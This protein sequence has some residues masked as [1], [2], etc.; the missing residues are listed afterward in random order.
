LTSVKHHLTAKEITGSILSIIIAAV[1]LFIA[2]KGIHPQE[3][4]NVLR[5]TSPVWALIFAFSVTLSHFIRAYRWKLLLEN[6]KPDI[7]VHHSFAAVMIG[8]GINNVVPRL[9]E[10]SRAVFLGQYE[11]ISRLSALGSIVLERMI[12]LLLFGAAVLIAGF[13]YNGDIYLHFPW[14]KMT[15]VIGGMLFLATLL[16]L[17]LLVWKGEYLDKM[18]HGKLGKLFPSAADR[19]QKISFRLIQGFASLADTKTKI[20]VAV[21]S[22]LIMLNYALSSLIGFQMLNLPINDFSGAWI[23]M[24]ISA[25]GVMIPTPG[26]IG[27]YHTITKAALTTLFKIPTPVAVAYAVVSHGISYLLTTIISIL[28]FFLFRKRNAKKE[29]DLLA[30]KEIIEEAG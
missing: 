15:F 5:S 28:Y 22:I 3:L 11:G 1:F 12:D 14:L 21:S 7:S 4:W 26:G 17:L 10:I 9:G 30:P 18:M 20:L 24:S 13:L 23:F 29:V 6:V 25:I 2:F 8:Y 16:F 19:L 27:S